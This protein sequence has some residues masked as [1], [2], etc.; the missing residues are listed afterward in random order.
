[1]IFQRTQQV[2]QYTCPISTIGLDDDGGRTSRFWASYGS[3]GYF[4][5]GQLDVETVKYW[6]S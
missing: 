4:P 1:M 2:L 6:G 5:A 3:L